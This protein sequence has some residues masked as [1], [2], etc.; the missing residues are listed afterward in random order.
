MKVKKKKI[1]QI[2][3]Y[4][5]AVNHIL[6]DKTYDVLCIEFGNYRIL[7]ECGEPALFPS[8]AF[9]IVDNLIPNDWI[10]KESTEEE[11]DHEDDRGNSI[12]Y[13]GPKEFLIYQYFFVDYFDD[14]SDVLNILLNYL[15]T[16]KEYKDNL[17]CLLEK[18]P[19]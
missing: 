7:D 8:I 2:P 1:L 15:C 19:Y 17:F 6:E 4:K 3:E 18:R 10:I 16:K 14:N 9:N 13:I 12:A 5:Y 11:Y